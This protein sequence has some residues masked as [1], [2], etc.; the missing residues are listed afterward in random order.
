MVSCAH[1]FGMNREAE[2]RRHFTS[3][4]LHLDDRV[5]AVGK[6]AR[7]LPQ[8]SLNVFAYYQMLVNLKEKRGCWQSLSWL[9]RV[10]PATI[11]KHLTSWPS[12]VAFIRDS[13]TRICLKAAFFANRV[14]RFAF[15]FAFS[16]FLVELHC[17]PQ[18]PPFY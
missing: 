6:Q 12:D 9:L 16:N 13:D 4:N 1:V 18:P 17:V 15:A 11:A 10:L 3:T 14:P 5:C 2:D 7:T 8:A